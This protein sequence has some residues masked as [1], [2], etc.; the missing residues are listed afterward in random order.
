MGLPHIDNFK[1]GMENIK[2]IEV[3]G[4]GSVSHVTKNTILEDCHSEVTKLIHKFV[5]V[6]FLALP[7]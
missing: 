6:R 3:I 2:E 5:T 4:K 1:Y 7:G